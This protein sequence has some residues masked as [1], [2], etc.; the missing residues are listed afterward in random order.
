MKYSGLGILDVLL[1]LFV[2]LKLIGVIN[3]PWLVVL[4]PL[5]IILSLV[6]ILIIIYLITYKKYKDLFK[7]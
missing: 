2:V 7:G 6:I 1:I 5:W 3:W 4:I